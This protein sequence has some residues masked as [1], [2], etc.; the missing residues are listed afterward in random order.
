MPLLNFEIVPRVHE[1]LRDV[2][3]AFLFTEISNQYTQFNVEVCNVDGVYLERHDPINETELPFVSV[4]LTD[5]ETLQESIRDSQRKANFEIRCICDGTATSTVKSDRNASFRAQRLSGVVDAILS[6]PLSIQLGLPTHNIMHTEV[7]KIENA[8][9]DRRDSG[10]V[11]MSVVSFEVTYGQSEV[12]PAGV[13][14]MSAF[15]NVQLAETEQGFQYVFIQT[16]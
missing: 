3:G 7:T 14:L 6:N 5:V 8:E 11:F 4:N 16:P 10:S 13:P 9:I 2:L 12:L 15:T 1:E